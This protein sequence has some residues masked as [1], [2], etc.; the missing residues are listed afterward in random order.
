[1]GAYTFIIS[2]LD[3]NPEGEYETALAINIKGSSKQAGAALDVFPRKPDCTDS[4]LWESV[5]S[6]IPTSGGGWWYFLKSKS[7]SLVITAIATGES[8]CSPHAV[9]AA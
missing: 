1:M 6:T 4:Q 3:E 9:K 2:Y 5:Q 8:R 7:N